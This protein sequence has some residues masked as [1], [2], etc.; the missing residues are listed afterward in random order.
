MSVLKNSTMKNPCV[1]RM[2]AHA[3]LAISFG[4]GFAATGFAHGTGVTGASGKSS[5]FF[6]NGCHV[7]G[8][9]P[10]VAFDGP[11]TMDRGSTATF[12]FTVAS[13]S[14]SQ[15]AA[16]LDV[17]ASGGTL[18][19]GQGTYLL[20]GEV[21]HSSP[22]TNDGNGQATFE[23]TWQAPASDGT[24]TLFGAGASVNGNMLQTGDRAARTT[25]EIVVGAVPPTPTAVPLTPT[26]TPTATE[27][28]T[29]S[30]MTCVGDCGSDGE[31]TVE[32]L[33]TGTNMALDL[34]PLSACPVFDANGD[35]EVTIDEMLQAVNSALSG[36]PKQ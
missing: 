20:G 30:G 35:G 19:A 27:V 13:H 25:Y 36:C 23:F 12:S 31:V 5:G 8:T 21:T 29:A 10:T 15:I 24:Y 7:G 11:T 6:C 17:A 32:E 3:A 22:K 28:P 4:V 14:A 1:L 16:G 26:P 34:T 2:A 18:V 9:A 33:I